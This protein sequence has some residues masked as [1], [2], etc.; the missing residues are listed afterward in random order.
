[1]FISHT[2]QGYCIHTTYF[3]FSYHNHVY[4][5]CSHHIPCTDSLVTDKYYPYARPAHK[6]VPVGFSQLHTGITFDVSP[7]RHR[8]VKNRKSYRNRFRP[9]GMLISHTMQGYCMHTTYYTCACHYHV[10]YTC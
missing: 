2:M 3:T 7:G 10:Y 4:Y 1:M 6:N 5:T 9:Y 8:T